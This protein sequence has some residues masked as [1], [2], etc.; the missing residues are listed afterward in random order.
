MMMILSTKIKMLKTLRVLSIS[1]LSALL[2]GWE[3]IK[4]QL[5]LLDISN[6]IS[7]L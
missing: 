4:P 5:I 2:S 6:K 3:G 7:Y 1:F